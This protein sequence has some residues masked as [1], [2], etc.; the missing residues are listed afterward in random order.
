M[1]WVH[2]KFKGVSFITKER[3]R[4]KGWDDGRK[5]PLILELTARLEEMHSQYLYLILS[6]FRTFRA[7]VIKKGWVII[8]LRRTLMQLLYAIRIAKRLLIYWKFKRMLILIFL[9]H[10]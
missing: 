10:F 4:E 7:F 3:K 2:R 5:D 6:S 9:T 8:N 1:Q